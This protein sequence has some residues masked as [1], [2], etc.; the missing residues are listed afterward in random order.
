MYDLN[1]N[2]ENINGNTMYNNFFVQMIRNLGAH[3]FLNC[4][5][6]TIFKHRA[7]LEEAGWTMCFNDWTDLMCAARVGKGGTVKQIAGP[8]EGSKDKKQRYISWA[9][10]EINFGKTRE[11]DD[12]TK[13]IDLTKA[14]MNVV[15]TCVFH[16][17][18]ANV[19]SSPGI[20]GEMIAII[21]WE[22]IAYQVDIIAGDGNKACYLTH[23]SKKPPNMP[24]YSDSLFQFWLK[25][26]INTATQYRK[27]HHEQGCAPVRL[28]N[29]I[30]ASFAGLRFLGSNLSGITAETYT[31][32]LA[33]KTSTGGDCCSLRV[34][35][36]GHSR[37]TIAEDVSAF[38]DEEHMDYVGEFYATVNETVLLADNNIFNLTST[39]E[40]AHHPVI[41]HFI[42]SGMTYS[43]VNTYKS[44]EMKISKSRKRKEKQNAKRQGY[45]QET[46]QEEQDDDEDWESHQAYPSR[47]PERKWIWTGRR[48]EYASSSSS[49]WKGGGKGRRG[50]N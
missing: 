49:S 2:F 5:A 9:I 1:E 11:R 41:V 30:S 18:H 34:I 3:I 46:W 44:A 10:F 25:R 35:E 13:E 32:E 27:K 36:W 24:T 17:G 37:L 29:F 48:N 23:P 15:R 22:C 42:P 14:R 50:W 39:D 33:K 8:N 26:M 28:K 16:I 6:S 38:D 45:Y 20:V 31:A 19:A 7:I 4:E 40:D 43:E 12:G 47:M 21:L